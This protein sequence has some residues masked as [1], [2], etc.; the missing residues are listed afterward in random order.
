MESL[1][2]GFRALRG[3]APS[4]HVYELRRYYV[5]EGKMDALKGRFGDH[6]DALFK[7]HNPGYVYR[8][9]SRSVLMLLTE[10][11]EV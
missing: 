1:M 11:H 4:H 8:A 3:P 2:L 10:V 9:E 7:R 5:H 6:T